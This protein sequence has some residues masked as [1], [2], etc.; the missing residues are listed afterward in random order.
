MKQIGITRLDEKDEK[1]VEVLTNLGMSRT[2]SLALACLRDS[3]K[4]EMARNI[5]VKTGLRQPEVSIAMKELAEKGWVNVSK[6]K[7][8]GKGRPI[9][10][11]ILR[12]KFSDIISYI[13]NKQKGKFSESKT[14]IDKL[15]KL[16]AVK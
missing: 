15:I 4:A 11:Y 6:Q 1:I 2:T 7:K 9:N 14:L 5:E 10:L 12:V 3:E 16:S 13:E 8:A